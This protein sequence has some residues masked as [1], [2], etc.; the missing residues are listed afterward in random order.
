MGCTLF[1]NQQYITLEVHIYCIETHVLCIA[2]CDEWL[3]L[4]EVSTY[5][6]NVGLIAKTH[7]Q[8]HLHML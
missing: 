1:T 8:I 2:I 5:I 3:S 7:L 6:L 4:L